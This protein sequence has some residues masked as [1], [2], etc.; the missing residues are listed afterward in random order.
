MS[1]PVP[2]RSPQVR[3]IREVGF[4]NPRAVGH[5]CEEWGAGTPPTRP[6]RMRGRRTSSFAACFVYRLEDVNPSE[7]LANFLGPLL[8]A[9][10]QV[11]REQFAV[12]GVPLGGFM[13]CLNLWIDSRCFFDG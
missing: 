5:A 12:D 6:P 13:V 10:V 3:R 9:A 7:P 1:W 2:K 4:C 8:N 11:R